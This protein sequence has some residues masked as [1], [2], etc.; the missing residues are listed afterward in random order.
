M[1]ARIGPLA[2]SALTDAAGHFE[3]VAVPH[4]GPMVLTI[5]KPGYV[6]WTSDGEGI[7]DDSG[8]LASVADSG[9][10]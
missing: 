4:V 8:N 1:R 9:A 3:L 6:P 5:E 7:R 2:R 10:G